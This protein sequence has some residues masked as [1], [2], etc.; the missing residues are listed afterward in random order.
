MSQWLIVNTKR[1]GGFSHSS[2]P[3]PSVSF[4]SGHQA[5]K[6]ESREIPP[7]KINAILCICA[8]SNW[9]LRLEKMNYLKKQFF[10]FCNVF[11]NHFSL[12]EF[13]GECD[14]Y[15]FRMNKGIDGDWHT[16]I[17]LLFFYECA[18]PSRIELNGL[19]F[20]SCTCNQDRRL[21]TD[22]NNASRN[23]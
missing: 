6:Q 20:L 23:C 14:I 12:F 5:Y 4:T 11:I 16:V 17:F 10:V 13:C 18:Q 15:G 3:C 9:N 7:S 2:Y 1:S 8:R 21:K 22:K 19:L